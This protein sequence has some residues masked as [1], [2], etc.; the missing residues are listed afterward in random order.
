ML[1]SVEELLAPVADCRT[2]DELGL[3]AGDRIILP[4]EAG[5]TAILWRVLQGVAYVAFPVLLGVRLR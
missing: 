3:Q 4:E 2:L 1:W 5:T